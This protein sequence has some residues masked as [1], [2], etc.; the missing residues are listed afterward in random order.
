MSRDVRPPVRQPG[1]PA[2]RPIEAA[3]LII[4][5]GTGANIEVLMGERHQKHRFMPHN[6]V[7][8]G[9]EGYT[10]IGEAS[11]RMV[12]DPLAFQKHFVP[13]SRDVIV[14]TS[15]VN[16]GQKETIHFNAPTAAGDYPF[17]CTYPGHWQLMRG[18]MIVY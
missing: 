8:V 16:P 10:R 15:V 14:H 9:F 11:M 7:L 3:T 17:L 4:H 2:T 13:E 12:S 5:R 6:W 1:T 18:T